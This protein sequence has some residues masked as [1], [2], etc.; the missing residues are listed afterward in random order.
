MDTSHPR[1]LISSLCLLTKHNGAPTKL[2][3][4]PT[5][6]E[7]CDEAIRERKQRRLCPGGTSSLMR[8]TE[9]LHKGSS[10][11]EGWVGI[12]CF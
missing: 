11:S 2:H 4:E 12:P 9:T 1:E 10:Q 3:Q 8:A 7:P 5:M 6:S